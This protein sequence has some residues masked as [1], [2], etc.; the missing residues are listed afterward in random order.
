[1]KMKKKMMIEN[2]P[3]DVYRNEHRQTIESP[4][5]ESRVTAAAAASASVRVSDNLFI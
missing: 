2:A 4:T 1:M 5:S 3:S